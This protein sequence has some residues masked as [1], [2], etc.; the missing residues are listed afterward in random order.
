MIAITTVLIRCLVEIIYITKLYG[1]DE[2]QFN[3]ILKMTYESFCKILLFQLRKYL[4]K[5]RKKS[6]TLK[7]QTDVENFFSL[8]AEQVAESVRRPT[9]VHRTLLQ[10]T[11]VVAYMQVARVLCE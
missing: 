9:A 3:T 11:R 4:I 10:L 2:I 6:T 8:G 5:F 7:V 1:A